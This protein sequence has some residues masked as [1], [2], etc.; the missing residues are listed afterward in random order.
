MEKT[1]SAVLPCPCYGPGLWNDEFGGNAD[2]GN[3][4]GQNADGQM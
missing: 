4:D 1:T 2:G 3:A